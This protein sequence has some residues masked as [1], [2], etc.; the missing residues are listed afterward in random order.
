MP[1]AEV[2]VSE[3]ELHV[4][5]DFRSMDS[6]LHEPLL[7]ALT[8]HLGF[9]V[10]PLAKASSILAPD[11]RYPELRQ[12]IMQARKAWHLY[13]EE[14]ITA[15][16]E[17]LIQGRLL[18]MMA[19]NQDALQDLFRGHMVRLEV[20]FA[21]T[22]TDRPTLRRMIDKG[23]IEPQ[24]LETSSVDVAFRLGRGLEM[25]EAHRTRAPDAD[26][27]MIVRKALDLE[28]T[29]QD[30]AALDYTKR[31]G[32]MFMRRPSHTVPHEFQRILNEAEVGSIRAAIN[33]AIEDRAD[34]ASLTRE[35]RA[36]VKGHPTLINDMER[37]ART[38]LQFAHSWGAYHALK[39]QTAAAGESDPE[40]YKFVNPSACADCRRIWGPMGSPHHYR[41]SYIEQ[42]EGAGGNFRLS[43]KQ[44]GPVIGP[45]HPNC[46]E[47]PLQ[48]YTAELVDTI[49][50]AADELMEMFNL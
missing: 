9:E 36:A 15:V 1:R 39:A 45:V 23:L 4:R 49:N 28:L 31:R 13:G 34:V 3:D 26:L 40:V 2:V 10:V 11:P 37:V 48:F 43:R 47:G 41:L 27:D 50:E 42:R 16:R 12:L 33:G 32:A 25:L 5:T 22:T 35:L 14:L 19:A 44:W 17:L 38:E 7:L 46:T 20:G 21:G 30:H 6:C 8:A 29:E 24:M 18:P